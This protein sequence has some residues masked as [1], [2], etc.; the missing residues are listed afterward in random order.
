MYY[1]VPQGEE[2]K[3]IGAIVGWGDTLDAALERVKEVADSISGIGI[4]IQTGSTDKIQ[5]EIA[6]LE[7]I[8]VS[9]FN[10]VKSGKNE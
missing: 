9:P 10:L 4:K 1:V 7:E 2:M 8:G 3:E 6:K 5:E